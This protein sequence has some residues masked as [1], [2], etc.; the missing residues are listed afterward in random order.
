[1]NLSYLVACGLM[2]TLLS[3]RMG[4]KPLSQAQQKVRR[5][6]RESVFVRRLAGFIY[7]L[8]QNLV[9]DSSVAQQFFAPF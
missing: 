2:I 4:A 1:M 8:L 6:P 9:V 7:A 3:V 5:R